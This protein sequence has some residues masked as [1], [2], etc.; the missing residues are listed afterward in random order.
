[1]KFELTAKEVEMAKGILERR[2]NV[3]GEKGIGCLSFEEMD[4]WLD[5]NAL[6]FKIDRW[7]N[8]TNGQ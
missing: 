5:I 7:Q 3:L 6:L 4:E 1:M 2:M 8:E